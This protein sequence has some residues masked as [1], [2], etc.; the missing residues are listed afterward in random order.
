MI[1]GVRIVA[2]QGA[3]PVRRAPGGDVAKLHHAKRTQKALDR[4][5]AEVVGRGAD[6]GMIVTVA[7][8]L[9]A[10]QLRKRACLNK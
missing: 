8:L 7:V 3:R 10:K 5:Q 6:G 1:G 4:Q 2:L 9:E